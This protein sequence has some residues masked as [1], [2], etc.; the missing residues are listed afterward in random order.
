[1][2]HPVNIENPVR[3]IS[4]ISRED[5]ACVVFWGLINNTIAAIQRLQVSLHEIPNPLCNVF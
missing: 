1:M 3:R 2:K 5:I 4:S